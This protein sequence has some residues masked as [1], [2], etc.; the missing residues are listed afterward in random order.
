MRRGLLLLFLCA[1]ALR[2]QDLTDPAGTLKRA[3]DRLAALG[4]AAEDKPWRD[5]VE[6]R[7]G[8]LEE[9]VA[10]R[11]DKEK[12][13]T[14]DAVESRRRAVDAALETERKTEVAPVHLTQADQITEYERAVQEAQARRD[15]KQREL[16]QIRKRQKDAEE[17]Q[18][19]LPARQADAT[20][21]LEELTKDDDL[22]Q[23]RAATAKIELALVAERQAFLKDAMARW[24]QLVP[25]LQLEHDL[26]K[27]RYDRAQKRYTQAADEASRLRAA[28][29]ERAK[30]QAEQE[31]QAAERER[32]PVE[33]FRR[34]MTAEATRTRSETTALKNDL[35]E[36]SQAITQAQEATANVRKER[37]RLGSRLRLQGEGNADLL[38]RTLNR[39]RRSRQILE[40]S[41]LPR[42][43]RAVS[44][45][46]T[47]LVRS[48]DRLWELQM[49][50]DENPVL[51]DFVDTLPEGRRAEGSDAYAAAVEGPDGVVPA[52][53]EKVQLLETIDSRYGELAGYYSGYET[54]LDELEQFILESIYW[55][56]SDVP[57]EPSPKELGHELSVL[58]QAAASTRSWSELGAAGAAALLG[59]LAVLLGVFTLAV[60]ARRRM[61]AVPVEE[62]GVGHTLLGLLLAL[63]P[64]AF[65]FLVAWV[66]DVANVPSALAEVIPHL[67]RIIGVFLLLDWITGWLLAPEGL[68]ARGLG[69]P[70]PML[71]ELRRSIRIVALGGI[72]CFAP[73]RV[74]AAESLRLV[75]LPRLLDTVWIAALAWALMR[76]AGRRSRLVLQLTAEGG[77]VRRIW[78]LV[79][80][81]ITLGLLGIVVMDVLGYRV[82]AAYLMLN[83]IRTMV[84]VLVV[85]ALY[86]LLLRGIRRA[87]SAVLKRT[88]KEEGAVAAWQS[89]AAVHNELTRLA[90][91]LL[92]TV[93]LVAFFQFWGI[94]PVLVHTLD[95]VRILEMGQEHWLTLWDVTKALLWIIGGHLVVHNLGAL[96]EHLVF[97]LIGQTDKGGRFVFLA[98][99]RYAIFVVA[100]SAAFLTLG[101]S[102]SNLGWLI[103]AASVGIG[104]GLQEIIA[105]FISGLILLIERPI[106]VGDIITVGDTGGTVEKINIRATT[107]VNWDRQAILI[108]NKNFITQNLTNW[109]HNDQYMRRKLLVGVAY[110]SDVEQVLRILD[111]VVKEHPK[112]L[113]DPPHRIWF[114]GFGDSS[115]NFDIWFFARIDEGKQV[116]T[117]INTKIYQ[118]FD[119]EGISIPFPQRDLHVKS[120][121]DA[122]GLAGLL[123]RREDART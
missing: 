50:A 26:E 67:L 48:L 33:R 60:R 92:V 21:R 14:A 118:R 3:Q 96:Y 70:A 95:G 7:I 115:L 112:V 68:I 75:L 79:G 121:P 34:T 63:L 106:R 17:E 84:A 16:D 83:A 77:F 73:A 27:L 12:L 30:Q 89:S 61:R 78:V 2:A 90:G 64:A 97:P 44:R 71:A 40:E 116:M 37:E 4:T 56:R 39:T 29:A 98:L 51:R 110:G 113:R 104:F 94:A 31:K 1:S 41:T 72:F 57:L 101:F 54:E 15:E 76:L 122:E 28:E 58:G 32:D 18:R 69:Q 46:Q 99:T 82:G 120:M 49:P 109:T 88:M 9:L 103:A 100:Y 53:R 45:I 52:L 81:L 111:E 8:F 59:G 105:N 123:D 20:K 65:V 10:T 23:Y 24:A 47:D 107:V 62:R 102:F 91:F 42:H 35:Q 80:P 74:L 38:R 5:A 114:S 119:A 66:V 86:A 117:E 85:A 22:T 13:P 36:V 93:S 19:R 55:I 108:P 25:V 6:R 43:Q 11:A 87:S